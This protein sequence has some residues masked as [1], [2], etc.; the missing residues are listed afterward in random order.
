MFY[1]VFIYRF[2]SQCEMERA[3]KVALFKFCGPFV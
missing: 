1:C 2:A 3:D